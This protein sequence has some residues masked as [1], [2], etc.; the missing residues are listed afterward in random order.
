[1]ARHLLEAEILQR[2]RSAPRLALHHLRV[3][4]HVTAINTHLF[5]KKA[6]QRG[7][8]IRTVQKWRWLPSA[9]GEGSGKQMDRTRSLRLRDGIARIALLPERNRC[10][11]ALLQYCSRG[12]LVEGACSAEVGGER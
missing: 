6:L 8:L 9:Q 7:N 12:F 3:C 1:M 2:I 4:I 10:V 5:A 11:P